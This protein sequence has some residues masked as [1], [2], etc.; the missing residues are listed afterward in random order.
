MS[1][2]P[3]LPAIKG[4][5]SEGEIG[6][7]T[8]FA[9]PKSL[10]PEAVIGIAGLHNDIG[11]KSGFQTDGYIDKNGMVYGEG[12]KL[13]FLPPG[14]DIANQDNADI[15]NMP[16]K[17]LISESYPGDGWEPSPRDVP[18]GGR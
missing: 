9:K 15:R 18:E 14:M 12:A 10:G 5:V 13:N 3:N 16:F 6:D 4:G 8:K 11:E 1:V 17:K 2:K 7:S